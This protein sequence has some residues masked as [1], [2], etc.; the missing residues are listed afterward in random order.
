MKIFSEKDAE[1]FADSE[2][3]PT[4]ASAFEKNMVLK[5]SEGSQ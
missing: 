4:F 2:K 3:V 5:N 1:I